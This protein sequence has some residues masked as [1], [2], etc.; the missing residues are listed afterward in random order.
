V[1]DVRIGRA[2]RELRR[3]FQ[4]RQVDLAGR[5]GVSQDL[6]SRI[7]TGKLRGI[8]YHTLQAVFVALGGRFDGL[9][10]FRGPELERLLDALHASVLEQSAG[11]YRR[12]LWETLSEVTF[13][14][15]GDRGSIDLLSLRPDRGIASINEIKTDIPSVEETHRRHD[16]KVRLAAK[17]VEDRVGWRPTAIGRILILP[18]DSRLRRIVDRHATVF[19]SSYPASSRDIRRWIRDPVGP[20]AGVWF[21]SPTQEMRAPQGVIARRRTRMSAP[22][23]ADPVEV[24]FSRL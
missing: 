23:P 5:A 9:V 13:Q 22:R 7:E 20:I 4:W 1:D 12:S 15:F 3:R 19:A 2:C 24:G 16:V 14:V 6:I 11:F 8:A 18:E 21:L 17:I 10:Q